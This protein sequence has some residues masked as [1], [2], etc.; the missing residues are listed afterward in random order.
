MSATLTVRWSRADRTD[1]SRHLRTSAERTLVRP[2]AG[3]S[4]AEWA[5]DLIELGVRL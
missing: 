3:P 2:A 4:V 1:R 5:D